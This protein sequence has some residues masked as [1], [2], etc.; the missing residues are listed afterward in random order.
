[1]LEFKKLCDSFEKANAVEKG[2]LLAQMSAKIS[3]RLRGLD[4]SD[5]DPMT[6]LAGFII[7][8]VVVDG[9]LNEQEYLLIYPALVRAFGDDFDFTSVKVS[10]EKD[11][12]GRSAVAEYTEKLLQI[13]D[14]LDEGI[15]ND[16]ITLCLCVISIDGKITLREKKY[17]KR[18][19]R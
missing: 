3:C 11:K 1:M 12:N 18:L 2:V 13:L 10:F 6:V 4:I 15:K 8:S 7:G 19:C 5:V 14:L 16:I 17:I 9:R